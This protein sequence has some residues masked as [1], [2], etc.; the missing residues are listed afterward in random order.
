MATKITPQR[1]QFICALRARSP[2]IKATISRQQDQ[3]A[4]SPAIGN[5]RNVLLLG[6]SGVG[7]AHVAVALGREAAPSS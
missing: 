2:L 7:K 6:Q 4:D 5:G 3:G 1:H